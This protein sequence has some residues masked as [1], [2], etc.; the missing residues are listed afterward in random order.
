MRPALSPTHFSVGD[1]FFWYGPGHQKVPNSWKMELIIFWKP[2]IVPRLA[3]FGIKRAPKSALTGPFQIGDRFPDGLLEVEREMKC[4]FG[5]KTGEIPRRI[6]TLNGKSLFIIQ[7]RGSECWPRAIIPTNLWIASSDK[8]F[9]RD[10]IYPHNW[11]GVTISMYL[12]GLRPEGEPFIDT[13]TLR[14]FGHS[15]LQ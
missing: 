10:V 8:A 5:G 15:F 2:H 3:K 7:N 4:C 14:I 6:Q 13:I 11:Y 12:S 9:F 1:P